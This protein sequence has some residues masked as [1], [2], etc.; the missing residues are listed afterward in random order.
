MDI[1]T[2]REL[3]SDDMDAVDKM[4]IQQLKSDVVLINRIGAYIVHSGGKRLRPMIVLLAARACGYVGGRHI[5][6]AAIIEF[7]HTATLLH[8]DVVD[9]SDLRRNRETA[10]TVWGNEASVLVGDFLYSRSFEMMVDVGRMPVMDVLS[11]A[12]N[13]IAEGEVLQLL[14]V[15]NPDTSEAEYMEVI[16]R[17]T[18]TL[19]EAG[20]RLGGIISEVAENQQQALADYGLRLGIA[21]Q[22]VDD[23]LD[24]NAENTE[25]GK[26]I[27]DDLA[28]GKPTLPLIQ[29]MKCAD[30]EKRRRLANIIENGGLE[31][32]DFVM[33]AIAD[34]DAISYTQQLAHQQAQQ[35]KHALEALPDT[36]YRQ[37][38]SN[39]ADFS[40]ARTN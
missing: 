3:I 39:L 10:N 20:T 6:L 1:T 14:N 38:L 2:I 7:I 29:A 30:Q 26:N 12:T 35:A 9:G 31:E 36:P 27:G 18:A 25:I 22:L 33:Q 37:A 23:A 11:H 21:F 17:K 15:H 5:D 13:R 40:V 24:Y 32:I 4:I 28:E 8:D 34:S 16:K 19:F